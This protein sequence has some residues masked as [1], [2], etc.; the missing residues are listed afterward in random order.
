MTKYRI[1]ANAIFSKTYRGRVDFGTYVASERKRML[2]RV[3]DLERE[4]YVVTIVELSF[5]QAVDK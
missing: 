3:K 1:E 2:A 5:P 4:G